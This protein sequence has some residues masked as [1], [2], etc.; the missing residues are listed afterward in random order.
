M[1]RRCARSAQLE[2]RRVGHVYQGLPAAGRFGAHALGERLERA[3]RPAVRTAM[4][5]ERSERIVGAAG[6]ERRE[7]G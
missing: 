2:E 6:G 1:L 4:P 3:E 7:L 5:A